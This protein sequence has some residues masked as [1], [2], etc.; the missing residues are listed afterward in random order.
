M[1]PGL[2]YNLILFI[3][4]L[5]FSPSDWCAETLSSI[6][7]QKVKAHTVWLTWRLFL[8]SYCYLRQGGSMI[9]LVCLFVGLS[10]RR[11]TQKVKNGFAW[12]FSQRW[13]FGHG[14]RWLHF[15]RGPGSGSRTFFSKGKT[16]HR[17]EIALPCLGYNEL[18]LRCCV[19]STLVNH[20]DK[21]FMIL[22][23]LARACLFKSC[24]GTSAGWSGIPAQR[25][26]QLCGR[27]LH[28]TQGADALT[29]KQAWPVNPPNR[30]PAHNRRSTWR[31]DS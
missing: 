12:R 21:V 20:G 3:A 17:W 2:C 30:E 4:A 31:D 28:K 8:F 19:S 7:P 11:I 9:D 10:V 27:R 14:N 24:R 5:H 15:G 26:L 6:W 16:T 13:V 25:V 1:C 18:L 23:L 22:P 29:G